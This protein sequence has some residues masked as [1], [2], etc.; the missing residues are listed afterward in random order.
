V[1]P[2]KFIMRA[3]AGVANYEVVN[4]KLMILTGEE[5]SIVME[6]IHTSVP[7]LM[8]SKNIV[9]GTFTENDVA[10]RTI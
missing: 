10:Q 5:Y 1:K 8:R 6:G 3:N 2:D 9:I 4:E 7:L